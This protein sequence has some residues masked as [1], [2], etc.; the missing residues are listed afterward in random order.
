[1]YTTWPRGILQKNVQNRDS[2]WVAQNKEMQIFRTPSDYKYIAIA[3]L[4][5]IVSTF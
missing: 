5:C 4:I 3:L 1:M 2:I